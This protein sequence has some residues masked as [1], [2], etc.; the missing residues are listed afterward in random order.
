MKKGSSIMLRL[1]T[2]PHNGR[3]KDGSLSTARGLAAM[4]RLVGRRLAWPQSLA[5]FVSS[6]GNG[7]CPRATHG[8]DVAAGRG[9][10]RR[11]RRLLLLLAAPGTQVQTPGPA[12]V[13]DAL[14]AADHWSAGAVGR[15]RFADQT[16]RSASSR[17]R[18]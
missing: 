13:D 14:G 7:L 16:L 15:G 8:D 6:P 2:S 10:Q 1:L 9:D 17:G 3:A 5:V 18:P 11:F 4:G 12:A